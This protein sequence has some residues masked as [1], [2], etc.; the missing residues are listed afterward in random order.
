MP[1]RC[2]HTRRS[3]FACT[4]VAVA[5]VIAIPLSAQPVRGLGDDALTPPRR[6]VRVQFSTSITDYRERYGKNTPGLAYRALEPLGIDYNID[7]LGVTKFPGLN[8]L[9]TALRTLTGNAGFTL[10]LGR[11]SLASDVRVQTTPIFVEAGITKRL[12][13]GLLIPIV[14]A[15]NLASLNVNPG[16]IGG[17]TSYNPARY[18]DTAKATNN[19]LISQLLTARDQLA[20]LLA[21]CTA[22][23]SSNS[24]CPVI[25]SSA[26]TINTNTTAFATGIRSVYGAPTST[27]AAFVPFAGS[28]ADSA[29]RNRVAAFRTQYQQFGIT[30]IAATTLGPSRAAGPLTPAGL[31]RALTDS[32]GAYAAEPVQNITR[33]G[34]GDIVTRCLIPSVICSGMID[35]AHRR[36]QAGYKMQFFHSL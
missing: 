2:E 35:F 33:Q 28:A 12:S 19:V 7:T 24:L 8:T 5:F 3:A 16:G 18:L 22:N 21:A 30:S 27:G 11:T 32:S 14:S 26:G 15:Q 17:N 9:Q 36:L 6:T 31:Q 25:L 10:N 23:G 34:F 29:I 1:E 4:L 20:T 13:I